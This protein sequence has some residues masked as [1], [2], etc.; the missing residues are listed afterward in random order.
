VEGSL[1]EG[2]GFEPWIQVTPDNRLAGG[3]TRP[4]CDPSAANILPGIAKGRQGKQVESK[5]LDRSAQKGIMLA[6]AFV[7]L[8]NCLSF[9]T[10]V[11]APHF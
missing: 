5:M 4:L 7:E 2:Q 9:R 6:A 10:I 8:V 3:R 11:A 1:A